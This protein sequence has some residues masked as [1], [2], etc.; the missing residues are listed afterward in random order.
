MAGPLHDVGKIAVPDRIL[1][2]PSGLTQEEYA[3][4]KAH[5]TY[6]VAIVRGVLDDQDVL[7]A[8]AEH[9]ERYDGHGYPHGLRGEETSLPGRIMQIADAVS[10]MALD[11]PYQRGLPPECIIAELRNGASA[12][13]DPTLVE[14]FIAAYTAAYLEPAG[15]AAPYEP[16]KVHRAAS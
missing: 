2:K 12:Q 5:V 7:A 1:R 6:G 14:P 15:T 13:F 9:H 3:A 8:I 16:P 11:R 10:A 4:I